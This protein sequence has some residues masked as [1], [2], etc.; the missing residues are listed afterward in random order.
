MLRQ[1]GQQFKKP[2]GL[3]GKIITNLMIKG[4]TP[5][6]DHMIPDLEIKTGDRILEI[7]Y[8]HGVGV[9]RIV[10]DHDCTVTGID[11]SELSYQTAGKRNRK[12]IENKKV[13]LFYGD[14]LETDRLTGQYDTIFHLNVIYF[15]DQLDKPFSKMK[16]LLKEGGRVC[17]FMAGSDFLK[18]KK[19]TKDGI[20]NK[21]SIEYVVDELTLAGFSDIS[22]HYDNGYYIK[23]RG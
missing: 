7:G 16:S 3:M 23:C 21:Y 12:H 15:W 6:Y 13:E 2:S 1:I 11:F 20:F 9:D 14:F 8:G 22:H 17:M 4:N 10:T 18:T 5:E 19:F